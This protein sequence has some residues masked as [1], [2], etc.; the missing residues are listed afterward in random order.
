LKGV[1]PNLDCNR[2]TTLICT[3]KA[4]FRVIYERREVNKK[5]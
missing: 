1:E 4:I 3:L 2:D 5:N